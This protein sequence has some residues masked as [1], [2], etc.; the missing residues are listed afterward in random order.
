MSRVAIVGASVAGVK[1]A[2]ALRAEGF[3]G[4]IVLIDRET[5]PTYD[6]PPLSKSFLKGDAGHA[7]IQLVT[8]DE[9]ERLDCVNKFGSAA[10]ALDTGS[11]VVLLESGE[12]VSFDVL[13]I[14]TGSRA[15]PSP[16]GEG[17]HIHVLRTSADAERL[18]IDLAS[19]SHLVVIGAGFIGAE[20]AATAARLGKRVSM[21]D[22]NPGPMSRALSTQL[23]GIFARKYGG[24]GIETHFGR[25]V[26]SLDQVGSGIRVLLEG[27]STIDADLALVGIGAMVNTEW[28]ARSDVQV[29]DGVVCDSAL[30]AQT[31]NGRGSIFAVGDVARWWSETR[32][33][34][35]RLE[36]WTNAV[37]QSRVV[38]H[39]IVHP[40]DLTSFETTEY[41]WTD[42]FDWKIQLVGRTTS[43]DAVTAG[44]EEDA[45]FAVLY[46]EDGQRLS[47]CLVVNWP[48]ALVE[49]RR[50]VAARESR[51][52]LLRRLGVGLQ[53]DDSP[54]AR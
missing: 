43:A 20:A 32:E 52:A 30:R 25:P 29:E 15:R 4:E 48:R 18:R 8:A 36:H 37:E 14:A 22:P 2:Q 45:R 21:V 53:M 10:V 5:H 49:A 54:N 38:A 44:S 23:S 42:Q 31:L 35:L 13:V 19:S 41:V 24:E 34:S 27:G 40:D 39:N 46:S 1:T 28:L 26:A 33:S 50:A 3:E 11:N 12:Q 16:W 6:K 9:L 47:G 51:S 7:D 17:P